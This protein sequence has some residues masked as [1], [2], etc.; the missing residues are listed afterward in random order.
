MTAGTYTVPSFTDP[1]NDP[2]TYSV[3]FQNGSALDSSWISFDSST[4]ILSYTPPDDIALY[5]LKVIAQDQYNTPTEETI[6]LNV[7]L[8]PRINDSVN[9]VSGTFIANERSHFLISALLFS[10]EEERHTLTFTLETLNGSAVPSW[11]HMSTPNHA[12]GSFVLS[13]TVYTYQYQVHNLLLV[14]TD[15]NGLS[16]K[17]T[18]TLI[19]DGKYT[20]SYSYQ[21]SW[22]THHMSNMIRRL[23]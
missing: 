15:S 20:P 6:D 18:V 14:A 16:N 23:D 3:T 19:V 2:I 8:K 7:D 12:F 21:Y 10:D 13:G 11:L 17:A 9:P 22:L 1:E 4:L 5:Q